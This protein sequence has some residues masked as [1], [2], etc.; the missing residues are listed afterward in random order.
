MRVLLSTFITLC[1]M[2][3]TSGVSAETAD[4]GEYRVNYSIISS[5][6]LNPDVAEQ[7]NLKRSR[8]LGVVNVSILKE[9]EDGVYRPIGGQIEGQVFNDLQQSSYLGFRRITEGEV[10]YYLAQF[11]YSNGELL[12]FQ[13]SASPQGSQR[14]LPVRIAKEL[15]DERQ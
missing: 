11:S 15:F 2:A 1:L 8:G 4:F 10:I 9:D 14:E 7:Y 13:I 12:T 5:T 6:F 3:V